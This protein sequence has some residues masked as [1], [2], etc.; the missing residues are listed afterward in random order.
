M[1]EFEDPRFSLPEVLRVSRADRKSIEN[2]VVYNH[3]QPFG[4]GRDRRFSFS[5][6]LQIELLLLLRDTFK[7]QPSVAKLVALASTSE[8]GVR[9]FRS[10]CMD[11][12]ARDGRV[13]ATAYRLQFEML[14]NQ[15][16][17]LIQS[18]GAEPSVDGVTIMLPVGLLARS[19]LEKVRAIGEQ[20]DSSTGGEVDAE[21]VRAAQL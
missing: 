8:Y 9:Q 7:V 15:T 17:E 5:H 14:R 3:V 19:V 1:F 20:S 13:G 4:A 2:W 12:L 10:D 21:G 6:V 18:D 16:G 11:M